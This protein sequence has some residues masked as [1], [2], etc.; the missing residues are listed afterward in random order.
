MAAGTNLRV[1]GT[2]SARLQ[3]REEEVRKGNGRAWRALASGAGAA[4]L[5]LAGL[6]LGA[7]PYWAARRIL[8]P[9]STEPPS[10]E[11]H[12]VVAVPVLPERVEF[13]ARDGK[14]LSGW[15]LPPPEEVDR[16]AACVVLAYGYGGYKEQMHGYAKI[17]HEGGFA[18][19][20][21]DMRGGGLR[22][23]EP[24][25]LGYKERWDLM[26]AV[27]YVR[28]RDDVDG[29]RVGVLGVSMGGATAIM[30]AE[31]DPHIKAI[32]ADSAFADIADMIRPGLA[33]FVG[34]RAAWLAKLIVFYAETMMG[35]K[36]DELRPM[37]SAAKMGPRPILIIHG[38]Q[39]QLT[40]PSSA[41]K[42]YEAA[43]GPKELWMVPETSHGAAPSV[44]P[45][46]YTERIVGFF[47]RYL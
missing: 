45:E 37:R 21:F 32:V 17:L 27:R 16:P 40:A 20:M 24:T 1:A 43:Q 25:T 47:R 10:Y 34:P 33:A 46:E 26:D 22:R 4:A 8:Y 15:Y 29:D 6:A 18:T 42:L 12:S 23:G 31:D 30:A 19:L 28:S 38:D 2:Y 39:D 35:V 11:P 9:A 5:G 44:A 41:H 36:A 7:F 14:R 13:E 3:G